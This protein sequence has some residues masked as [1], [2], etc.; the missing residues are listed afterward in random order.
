MAE[1][2]IPKD[3]VIF[4][5]KKDGSGGAIAINKETGELGGKLGEKIEWDNLYYK[6][7]A[8]IREKAV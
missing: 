3:K 1:E 6:H 4:R 7:L 5:Q 8:E 2:H